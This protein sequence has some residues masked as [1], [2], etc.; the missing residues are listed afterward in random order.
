V[1][2]KAIL[3][4]F[5]GVL[6]P[7][8]FSTLRAWHAEQ[9]LDPAAALRTLFGPYDQD[10]DHPWH[11]LERGEISA[12]DA[13]RRIK[14]SAADQGFDV[15]PLE[16]FRAVGRNFG[17]RKDVVAKVLALRAAGYLTA[18]ITNNVREYADGWRGLIPAADM[19]DLVLDSSAVGMRKPDPRIYR[20]ALQQLGV[21]ASESV[22]LDDAPG[23]VEAA[24]T[25]GI[26]AILVEDDP[27]SALAE[28]DRV[29]GDQS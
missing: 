15:D 6:T 2:I 26:H 20:M 28:L 12:A 17:I 24:R 9:G 5:G 10:T 14:A 25:L 4:D 23:N 27:S 11:Q 3:F 1:A 13:M 21:G 19:F 22:F 8:P 7:S 16:V 18:L 29:L